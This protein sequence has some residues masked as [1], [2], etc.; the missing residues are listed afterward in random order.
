MTGFLVSQIFR[1]FGFAQD[2]ACGLLLG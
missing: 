1:S 2:F